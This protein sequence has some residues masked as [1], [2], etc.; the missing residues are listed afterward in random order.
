MTDSAGLKGTLS[1]TLSV[2][3]LPLQIA[4]ESDGKT[5]PVIGSGVVGTAY[6]SAFFIAYG[7]SNQGM[8][9]TIS[10]ALPPGITAGPPPGCVPPGCLIEFAGTPTTAGIFPFTLQVTDSAGNTTSN[11]LVL[12]INNPGATPKISS[13]T[14]PLATIGQNYSATLVATGGTG[15]LT[16]KIDGGLP[17][18]SLALTAG[19]ALSAA[20]SIPNDFSSGP[21]G[22]LPPQFPA[23]K[24]FFVQ[25]TDAAGQSDVEQFCMPAYFPQPQIQAVSPANALPTGSPVTI[26]VQGQSFQA[27]SQIFLDYAAQPTTF[28]SPTV[29]QFTMLP[30][31]YSVLQTQSGTGFGPYSNYPLRV[32]APYT[33]PSNFVNFAISLPPLTIS[34]VQASVYNTVRPCYTGAVCVL[35]VSGTGFTAYTNVQVVGGPQGYS[36]TTTS[37]S[38]P[39]TQMTILSFIP[40]SAGTYTLQLSNPNQP[41]GSTA[42]A[43]ATFTA[44]PNATI[45]PSPSSF[46]PKFTEG[47]AAGSASM[48]IG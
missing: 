12:A 31:Q 40:P 28:V 37:A 29:V 27:S 47:D 10:G 5:P 18:P 32:Q 35:N 16:W 23:S 30:S 13:P 43:S 36:R 34:G 3:Q 17:D 24:V 6:A 14:L 8:R 19:G 1:I 7:G 22:Y 25:V 41:D 48:V 42:S 38:A 44:Y 15:P 45:V 21:A 20:P 46:N 11:F 2:I 26:T 9:W 39:W 4:D 33:T